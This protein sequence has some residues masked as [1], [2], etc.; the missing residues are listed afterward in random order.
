MA[1]EHEE[2]TEKI[3]GAAIKVHKKLGPGFIDSIYENALVIELRKQ[4]MEVD[5]Q[6]EV[7]VNY[8]GVEVGKHRLDLLVEKTIILELK[9]IKQ[10]EDIHYAIV[11]SYLNALHLRHG[12]IM[13]FAR[14]TLEVKRVIS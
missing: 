1:L 4:G 5:Q 7:A 9:A 13:N 8:E 11:R 10:I 2:L 12:L 6:L 14:I 3:I